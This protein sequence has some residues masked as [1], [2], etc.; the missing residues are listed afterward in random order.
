VPLEF[1]VPGLVGEGRRRVRESF[2]PGGVA[3]HIGDPA[4]AHRTEPPDGVLDRIKVMT[5]SLADVFTVE[6]VVRTVRR[7]VLSIEDAGDVT[8]ALMEGDR[9]AI[10]GPP[11]HAP[12]FATGMLA[13]IPGHDAPLVT[14]LRERRPIYIDTPQELAERYPALAVAATADGAQSWAFLPLVISGRAIGS[15][16]VSF[17]RPH[18]FTGE[19][20]V[21]YDGLSDVLA[22]TL[23]RARLYDLERR[24]ARELQRA[25]LP[26]ALPRLSAAT[27]AAR[28]LPAGQALEVGGDW[29]DVIPLSAERVA[30]VIGDVMGHGVSEA[31]TMGRLRTA[32][33]TLADLELP[34]DELMG[35]LNE[36]VHEFGDDFFATCLFLLY[37]PVT[38]ECSIVRAGH[39]P[40]AIVSPDGTVRFAAGDSN[41][42]LG[43]ASPP[44]D[45]TRL[46][47]PEGSLIVLYTD[48]LVE[49]ATVEVDQG[50]ENLARTLAAAGR[51]APPDDDAALQELCDAVTGALL[52]VPQATTD[53]AAL[54]VARVHGLGER[55]VAAWTLPDE[56]RSAGRAR[57]HVREM[58]TEWGLD[59]LATTTELLV[60]ELIGNAVRHA[61]GPLRL[62]LL[63][64]RVLTCEVA[65]GSL[66]T[67]RIRRPA[68]TDEEGRGLQLV[69]AIAQRWGTRYDTTGK[70]IWT[71]Q[72]LP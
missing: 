69:A 37:D 25:L 27:T 15:L 4:E 59:E 66:T 5:A 29:Y 68:A 48:G 50:M 67:P 7:L 64:G 62:R 3:L 30:L 20:R 39:P 55:D 65:D 45:T 34:P 61:R 42:P 70:C 40:P 71:E 35:H 44:F 41:P 10:A 18:H 26:Q 49:S 32:L 24:R 47:L 1:T 33:R 16:A 19:E 36:L 53:D 54:L 56:P 14:A 6:D 63:R 8:F 13:L 72:P 12:A 57:R 17:S 23:E 31:A 52:P 46:W 9:L 51:H 38:R 22:Q 28:Y 11:G 2:L 60:S 21:M 43:A 58:L